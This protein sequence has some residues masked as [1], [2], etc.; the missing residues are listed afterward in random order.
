MDSKKLKKSKT[1]LFVD[2][3]I[4]EYS[5]SN[6]HK[7]RK[8]E[9]SVNSFALTHKN[10]DSY[11]PIFQDKEKKTSNKLSSKTK[12]SSSDLFTGYQVNI[13]DILQNIYTEIEVLAQEL[14]LRTQKAKV[15]Q[16]IENLKRVISRL[17][18]EDNANVGGKQ[19]IYNSKEKDRDSNNTTLPNQPNQS[20]SGLVNN[21]PQ[22][23]SGFIN[24]KLQLNS[25]VSR[26]KRSPSKLESPTKRTKFSSTSGN[27]N[28]ISDV[29]GH[30]RSIISPYGNYNNNI[31]NMEKE[32]EEQI[33]KY[34]EEI[35][36]LQQENEKLKTLNDKLEIDSHTLTNEIIKKSNKYDN[37]KS[38]YKILEKALKLLNDEYDNLSN[39]YG[40]VETKLKEVINHKINLLEKQ[41]EI[42]KRYKDLEQNNIKQFHS[43]DTF[44]KEL[45]IKKDEVNSSLRREKNLRMEL[46]IVKKDKEIIQSELTQKDSKIK[47]YR[48]INLRLESVVSEFMRKKEFFEGLIKEHSKL[49]NRIREF[50][51]NKEKVEEEDTSPI[52]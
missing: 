34:N 30:R 9:N 42:T 49:N 22:F 32:F 52:I 7:N 11:S 13:L 20:F 10:T 28:I 1:N 6:R 40:I 39:D 5:S 46:E 44:T 33:E 14:T 17:S 24:S 38:K 51:K 4:A 47:V 18:S 19:N 50:E 21:T 26:F 29:V 48:D 8:K 37:I 27:A 23:Q 2:N 35:I 41:N 45:R 31:E 36:N 15:S 3:T 12:L 25:A 43:L 16:I